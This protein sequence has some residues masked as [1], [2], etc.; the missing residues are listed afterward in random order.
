MFF[1]D[2]L[3][4]A[5]HDSG[6]Y[7]R[8]KIIYSHFY[9]YEESAG[10]AG[11]ALFQCMLRCLNIQD[12]QKGDKLNLYFLQ[13]RDLYR[14]EFGRKG[15]REWREIMLKR[16]MTEVLKDWKRSGAKKALNIVG[17]RQVGKS[18]VVREFAAEEYEV[19]IELNFIETPNAGQIFEEAQS[20]RQIIE[21]LTAFTGQSIVPHQTLILLD[22]IQECP[23]ARTAL[24]FLVEDDRADYV[25]TGSLLGVRLEEIRSLPVGFERIVE[26]YPMDFEEFAWAAGVQPSAIDVLRTH[27]EQ[28]TPVSQAVHETWLRLFYLWMIVGGMPEV[29]QEYVDSHDLSRVLSLQ[30]DILRLY[31]QDISKYAR[32]VDRLRIMEIFKA[33]PAQLDQKNR[34]FQFNQIE[35]KARL[36][37]LESSFLW[38]SEAGTALPCFN[39]TAPVTPL[40]L[41]EKRSLFRLYQSD[42]GLLCAACLQDV[43]FEILQGN[44]EINGGS[45][46]ENAFAQALQSKG[47]ELYYYEAKAAHMELDFVVQTAKGIDVLEIKSGKDYRRHRSLDK[48]LECPDWTIDQAIVFAP[49]NVEEDDRILYLPFYMILF[50]QTPRPSSSRI[51]SVDLAALENL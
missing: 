30:K 44:L 14:T 35:P 48:A 42:T 25:E 18:T 13:K 26:M 7:I 1:R 20:A 16:K 46:L 21:N 19:F 5:I 23:A 28:K 11:P 51:Y 15:N 45:I 33:I 17:A 29:V 9:I 50:Y 10:S 31:E 22:E 39:V 24:K 32:T 43:Q 27:Y 47:R 34:R 40:R 8:R 36:R 41:N 6:W 12:L 49:S 4:V 2:P 37:E 3:N 38:L